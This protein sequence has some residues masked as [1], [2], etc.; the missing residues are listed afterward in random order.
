MHSINAMMAF[1]LLTMVDSR[2]QCFRWMTTGENGNSLFLNS[3]FEPYQDQWSYL[4]SV[5]KLSLMQ[6]SSIVNNNQEDGTLGGICAITD[7]DKQ[8]EDD[9]WTLPPSKKKTVSFDTLP[10]TIKVVQSNLL[11][12]D[13]KNLTPK[14]IKHLLGLAA[15]QNPEFYKAQRMTSRQGNLLQLP[16]SMR[17]CL[18]E[19]SLMLNSERLFL[20]SV[21][22]RYAKESSPKQNL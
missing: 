14:V 2:R 12:I 4:A 7:P 15:F 20:P 5:K 11:Y 10:E 22:A 21:R 6:L 19:S 13:K 9:P 18:G 17:T 16:S 8:T 1:I 3:D